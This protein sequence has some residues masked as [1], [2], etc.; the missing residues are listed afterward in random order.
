MPASTDPIEPASRQLQLATGL[1]YHLLEWGAGNAALTHTVVL[2][3]GFLDY[4]YSW[5]DTVAAGLGGRFHLIAPDMRGHG[6]S[7]RI[8]PGGYYHFV[9]YLADLH[10]V[11]G[12]LG[13]Q[14]VSL[15]GHSMG[16]SVVSY[17]AGSYPERISHLAMLEG[18][19]PPE[20]DLSGW[21]DRVRAW[22]GAWARVRALPPRRYPSLEEAALRLR[23]VDPRLSAELALRLAAHGTTVDPSG[24]YAF[25][26]DP[27]HNTPGPYPFS[28]DNAAQ[29][30]QR[31]ACPVLFV[32]ATESDFH[33]APDDTA[34]RIAAF[35]KSPGVRVEQLA[36]AGHMM[37]RH[38][39]QA[40][41]TLLAE[42]LSSP[43][44][45]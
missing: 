15:V 27:L 8:G 28:I 32:T 24:G 25:K 40:L 26:H 10:E 36:G 41:A 17:Y 35:K 39:P 34:R 16:G 23:K 20:P 7:D 37:Q 21:P 44:P 33:L 13:R 6:D 4:A 42:F 45:I 2:V 38:Q 31:V 29:F 43:S 30:W 11:I 5:A 14:R 12:Q 22:L 3:H 19:G 18:L 1:R 9:D